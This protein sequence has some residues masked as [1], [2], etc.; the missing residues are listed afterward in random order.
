MSRP[1]APTMRRSGGSGSA[2]PER[3]ARAG[4]SRVAEPCDSVV[5][6]LAARVGVVDAL[7][8]ICQGQGEYARYAARVATLDTHRDLEVARKVDARLVIPGDEEW[9]ARLDDL[10]VPPWCLWVRGSRDLVETV[11]R[12]VA[13][14]GSRTATRYGEQLAADLAAGVAHRGWTVVSGAALGI[15]GAAHRGALAVEGLTVAVLAGG[16]DRA[17]TAAKPRR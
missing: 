5:V 17:Y 10:S 6:K 16:V 2:D 4:L 7:N 12:S 11:E 9:P 8:V 3:L 15:D 14:V 1:D 13:V